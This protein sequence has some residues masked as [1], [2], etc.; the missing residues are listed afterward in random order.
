MEATLEGT[1]WPAVPLRDATPGEQVLESILAQ[2]R[3]RAAHRCGRHVLV[4][5]EVPRPGRLVPVPFA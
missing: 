3:V 2:R 4:E 5:A 1:R